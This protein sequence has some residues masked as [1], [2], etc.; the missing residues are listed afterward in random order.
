MRQFERGTGTSRRSNATPGTLAGVVAVVLITG[1]MVVM[2][3]ACAEPQAAEGLRWVGA[4][5]PP[6]QVCGLPFFQENAGKWWRLPARAKDTV[7]GAAWGQ[8]TE[9]SGA[10]LRLRTDS[11]RLGIR[12]SWDAVTTLPNLNSFEAAGVDVYLDGAY[13]RTVVPGGT[14]QATHLLFENL[15][16]REREV[17]IYLPLFAEVT[18]NEL[19]FDTD[20]ALKAPAPFKVAK[21]VVYYGTS[22]THGGCTAHPGVTY[23]AILGRRLNLDFVSFGFSGCGKGEP[24]VAGLVAEVDASCYVLDFAQ[25][26]ESADSLRHVYLPFIETLRAKH[27]ET[28]IL[29]I[30]PIYMTGE[31]PAAGLGA[32]LDGHRQVIRD[33]VRERQAKG[34]THIALVEGN[35]DML[36]PEQGDGLLDGVHPNTLG[37][38]YMANGLEPWLV[39]ALRPAMAAA[40]T[41]AP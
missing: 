2:S 35:V 22:I 12:L 37:F 24:V 30:A 3:G 27:P 40:G 19:G 11:S 26:N 25:N 1:G 14:G 31:S 17:C 33:A 39:R 34:D 13:Y 32:A 28:P 8:S 36:S 21:P 9:S 41:A 7:P 6:V 38:Q 10:R 5:E 18:V 16:R 29:C 20:A 23:Q 4:A 15:P